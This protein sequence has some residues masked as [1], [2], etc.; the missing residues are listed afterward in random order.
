M[1][2]EAVLCPVLQSPTNPSPL[3]GGIDRKIGEEADV[4]DVGHGACDADELIPVPSGGGHIGVGHH[5]DDTRVVVDGPALA[6]AG[7][8]QPPTNASGVISAVV[9]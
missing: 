4:V 9:E 6:E 1:R 2:T 8:M 5:T 3:V 7:G